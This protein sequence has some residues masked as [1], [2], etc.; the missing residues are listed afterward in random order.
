MAADRP[1][2]RSRGE[3][4]PPGHARA[5]RSPSA[6]TRARSSSSCRRSTRPSSSPCRGSGRSSRPGLE[7]KLAAI[8]GE[9]GEQARKGARGRDPEGPP[10]AGGRGRAG[11]ARRRRRQ[12]A[13]EAMFAPLRKGARPR[14]GDSRS[15]SAPRRLRSRCS[16]SSTRSGS[17]SASSG[18]CRRPAASR[19]ST[20]P[21]RSSSAPS[22]RPMPGIEIRLADDGEVLVKGDSNM[23]GYRNH[24]RE[25][26]RD[27]R[28]GRLAL[29]GDIGELDS[30][31]YLK[32]VD[33]KKELIINA[34][35]KNMSP[36]NIEAKLKTASPLIGQAVAIGDRAPLQRRADHPRPRLR[37]RLGGRSRGSSDTSLEALAGDEKVI[38]AV[39]EGVDEANEQAGARRADQEVQ[40]PADRLAAG[41]RRADADDEAEAQAD[42]RQVRGRDRGALREV[43]RP[44]PAP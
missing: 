41:R 43:G 15:T 9:Q 27:D 12:A 7:A 36:A 1:H 30:D 35:G 32:I 21:T 26:R 37:A 42:R 28:R 22:A 18:A 19:R 24:A 20:R 31:G 14:R 29:T 11:G 38:A 39:Q 17:R 33:R 2:R 34:A 10:R 6:P 16:S 4:L 5:R 13:D 40:A 44:R 23:L 3:L 8:P 25:D